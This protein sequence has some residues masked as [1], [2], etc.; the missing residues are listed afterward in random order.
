MP[1]HADDSAPPAKRSFPRSDPAHAVLA[2]ILDVVP[3][4]DWSFARVEHNGV[5]QPSDGTRSSGADLAALVDEYRR[6][7]VIVTVGPR[8]AASLHRFAGAASGITLIF[9]D[10]RADYG[11]L[12]LLRDATMP[13]FSSIEISILTFALDAGT[14]RLAALRLHPEEQKFAVIAASDGFA[15]GLHDEAFYVLDNDMEIVLAWSA[16]RQRRIVITGMHEHI[17]ERLPPVL[18]RSVRELTASWATNVVKEPGIARP[19][20]FLV[21]RTQP[22]TGPAGLFVGVRIDRFRPPNSLTEAA[23]RFHISPREAQVLALLL[24]GDHLDQIADQLKIT[25]STVQDHIKSMLDKTESRNRSELIA[26]ILGW[27]SPPNP[28][29]I[30]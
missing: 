13:P 8:I 30:L 3:T 28:R 27:E 16:E 26:R 18:E 19:V 21:V 20:P 12:T 14:D 7:R 29:A 11:I 17:A 2:G 5:L 4:S 1:R 25:S 10:E 9:A 22:M 6:Q 23:G 24:D 15:A